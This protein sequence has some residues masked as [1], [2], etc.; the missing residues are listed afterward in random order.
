MHAAAGGLPQ[1]YDHEPLILHDNQVAQS[2][3]LADV[4]LTKFQDMLVDQS[5]LTAK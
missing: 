3:S 5:D 1:S 4:I 2:M